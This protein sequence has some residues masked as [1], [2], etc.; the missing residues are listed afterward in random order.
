MVLKP[1]QAWLGFC[2]PVNSDSRHLDLGQR[3][4]VSNMFP[5]DAVDIVDLW[6]R[7]GEPESYSKGRIEKVTL[8]GS[9][10]DQ[11][12]IV[13][14]QSHT[15]FPPI[16]ASFSHSS[17]FLPIFHLS[18]YLFYVFP[19]SSFHF[20]YILCHSVMISPF[21][22]SFF[23]SPLSTLFWNLYLSHK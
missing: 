18:F 21:F 8:Q 20:T 13:S 10:P 7:L 3:R 16:S 11:R 12:M 9:I 17:Y 1:E 19:I 6:A 23:F 5:E 2:Y 22:C 4:D 15:S 14:S